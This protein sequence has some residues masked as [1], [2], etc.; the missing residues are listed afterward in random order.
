MLFHSLKYKFTFY[1]SNY[2]ETIFEINGDCQL[3]VPGTIKENLSGK[4][5]M[6]KEYRMMLLQSNSLWF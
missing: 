5:H 3:R 6:H 1:N 2:W 4:S